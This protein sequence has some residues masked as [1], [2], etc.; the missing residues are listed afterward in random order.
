M[1]RL[2]K[3]PLTFAAFC[4]II[5]LTFA[6][7]S[8]LFSQNKSTIPFE[9]E[10]NRTILPVKVNNSR[11]LKIILD[12]GMS[13]D[14]LL[15]YNPDLKDSVNLANPTNVQIGGAGNDNPSTA[16]MTDSGTFLIGDVEIKNQRII[17]LQ[18]DIYK[19]FPTDGVLGYSILGHYAVEINYDKNEMILHNYDELII[20]D[21]WEEIPIYFKNNMIPWIDAQVVVK[22]EEPIT[23]SMYIDYA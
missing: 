1:K 14:G 9:V 19:G 13:F 2:I 8:T 12:S 18:N 5:L 7:T 10:R 21:S 23:L 15:I 17:V 11:I 6:S 20:D 4:T 22:N 16:L 3:V